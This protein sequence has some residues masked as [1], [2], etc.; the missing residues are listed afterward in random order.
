[1]GLAGY[2]LGDTNPAAQWVG[3]NRNMLLG[4]SSQAMS[5]NWG[6]GA[7]QQGQQADTAYA[8]AEKEKAARAEQIKQ[9][10]AAARAGGH[11]QLAVLL[12]ASAGADN[13]IGDATSLFKAM[14]P[15][16]AQADMPSN[17]QEWEYYNTLDPGQKSEYLRMK[18]AT[19]YL[20]LGTEFAQPDPAN[21]G[22]IAGAPIP[23][24]NEQAAFDTAT[25]TGLGKINADNIGAAG[26]LRSKLPGLFQVVNELGQ[27]AE[28]ATYT[29][30]G[31]GWDEAVKQLG[32]EP[33]GAAIARTKYIAMVDNQVLPLLRDTFGAA[34]TVKEGETLRATL[35][36]PNKS[37]KEKQA[38]LEA[39]IE[40][41]VRDVEAMESRIPAAGGYTV[42]GVE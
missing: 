14:D 38:V 11:E 10:A 18:R 13:P 9:A 22:Q 37:P 20:D 2:L 5:G 7:M 25:G 15:R 32:M 4:L 28:T 24:N 36:D 34:F 41:K 27:L 23:I 31:Q 3:S 26:S 35:G 12:E 33:S 29:V 6:S 8:I 30:A 39:F 17:I 1:M 19:P 42:L 21:P 40:Q 16:T